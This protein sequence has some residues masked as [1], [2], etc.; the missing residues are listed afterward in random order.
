VITENKIKSVKVGTDRNER[1]YISQSQLNKIA[2]PFTFPKAVD[3][4]G[5]SLKV[6]GQD[7]F[8][9]PSSEQPVTIYISDNGVGQSVGLTL[10]PVANL[11]AQSIV[12]EPDA[13]TNKIVQ[14][15]IKTDDLIPSDYV[16]RI[17]S[18]IK[19]LALGKTPSGFTR[20]S[21]PTATAVNKQMM[22]AT[23]HKYVGSTY[24]IFSYKLTSISTSPV[25]LSEETFYTPNV[26][27]VAFFP[28]AMLQRGESTTV[29]VI[30]DHAE[31]AK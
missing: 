22:F 14:P 31:A 29:F 4:T 5:A 17:T 1:I 15:Q 8:I 18:H 19:Q 12:I 25:E 9:Q 26:R 28:S 7:V 2:T 6:V 10:V 11:P 3:V 21:L 24:D 13:S 30:A 27:A 23:Q 20:S 16:G